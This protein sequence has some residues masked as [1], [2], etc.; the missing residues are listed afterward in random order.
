MG[1]RNRGAQQVKYVGNTDVFTF[2]FNFMSPKWTRTKLIFVVTLSKRPNEAYHLYRGA[3]DSSEH[4]LKFSFE[5]ALFSLSMAMR[6]LFSTFWFV[7]FI[8]RVLKCDAV[9]FDKY[10]SACANGTSTHDITAHSVTH[11]MTWAMFS[12]RANK[13][14][15]MFHVCCT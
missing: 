5:S 7:I 10:S 2:G 9:I 13:I 15:P 6:I 12:L 11:G 4:I 1:N 3:T 14:G 8:F